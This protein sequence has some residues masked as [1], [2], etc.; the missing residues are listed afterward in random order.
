MFIPYLF[1]DLRE[2]FE[3]RGRE[4]ESKTLLP[5][6]QLILLYH[7][8]VLAKGA[9]GKMT[10]FKEL[11]QALD[12]SAMAITKAAED[13]Q[14][15][16]LC[17]VE[18]KREKTFLFMG[19]KKTFWEKC[20]P[21]LSSP[22]LGGTAMQNALDAA[23]NNPRNTTDIDMVLVV[24]VI[25]EKFMEAFWAM[26]MDG[27]YV[28]H[29]NVEGDKKQYWRFKGP[30]AKGFPEEIEISSGKL[31]LTFPLMDGAKFTPVPANGD[32]P[33]LSAILMDQD[34]Y[35]FLNAN[36]VIRDDVKLA[37]N[38]ALICL[39][40]K[41]WLDLRERK[42]KGENI[43]KKKISKHKND[44]FRLTALIAPDTPIAVPGGI[45]ADLAWF[46]DEVQAELPEG[47]LYKEMGMGVIQSE[48]VLALL[49]SAFGIVS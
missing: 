35:D 23:P 47:V 42:K 12:Y 5:S 10:S 41:A 13:L 1:L 29:Q 40:S 39:K 11:A 21:F 28:S 6:A 4:T 36:H 14:R 27:E 2:Q 30:Q 7:I 46:A 8:Y 18:G 33:S 37:N 19:D 49:R 15:H 9:V 45:K 26:I 31:E 24:D 16:K 34:Y 43:D 48:K 32:V 22:V 38:Y 3:E 17:I 25:D 20:K 44:V